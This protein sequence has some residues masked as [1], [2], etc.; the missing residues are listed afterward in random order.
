MLEERK[1]KIFIVNIHD[2]LSIQRKQMTKS[3]KLEIRIKNQTIY[4][5]VI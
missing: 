1:D 3:A 5:L 4:M 2:P